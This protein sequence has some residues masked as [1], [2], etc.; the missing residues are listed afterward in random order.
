MKTKVTILTI[1]L[2]KISEI[3]LEY[4]SVPPP[5]NTMRA[6]GTA[7]KRVRNVIYN[8]TYQKK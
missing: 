5:L 2:N 6:W 7:M 8:E 4:L 1:K 3:C